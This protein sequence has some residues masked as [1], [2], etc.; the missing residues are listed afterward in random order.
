MRKL[1]TACLFLQMFIGLM[2]AGCAGGDG[3]D[4]IT[5]IQK[6]SAA[7]TS[8]GTGTIWYVDMNASPGGNGTSWATA[9]NTIEAVSQQFQ[10]S[11]PDY[12]DY[13]VWIKEG[14]YNLSAPF[15]VNNRTRIYGGFA[16]NETSLEQR[17]WIKHITVINGQDQFQGIKTGRSGTSLTVD[18]LQITHCVDGAISK[19]SL[20]GWLIVMNC[21]IADNSGGT[22]V[23]INET[24]MFL[25]A[26]CDFKNNTDGGAIST[27]TNSTGSIDG[28]TFTNNHSVSSGGA[29]RGHAINV[30]NSI[31]IGNKAEI[32]GGAISLERGLHTLVNC[33]FK[34][35]Y[36]GQYGGAANVP[37]VG[38]GYFTNCTFVGNSAGVAGGALYNNAGWS[39]NYP[40]LFVANSILWGNSPDQIGEDYAGAAVAT[41]SDIT[42]CFPGIGNINAK[43]KFSINDYHLLPGSPCIDT[44]ILTAQYLPLTDFKGNP[45]VIGGEP[46]MG[47]L[48][49]P[50]LNALVMETDVE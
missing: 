22:A 33:L 27:E 42:G 2:L 23:N 28:C 16:G 31:F 49:F 48:E 11:A 39:D 50:R 24:P 5:G 38:R 34:N 29:I 36:A 8:S 6:I 1:K 7:V 13:E 35:N 40:Q 45:R 10:Q 47:Y 26:N 44:G 41:Y 20:G 17:D 4:Q 21:T 3:V 25:I 32:I 12:A 43:P 18:G 14:T 46:D 15:Y 9:F 37:F 19:W 30:I